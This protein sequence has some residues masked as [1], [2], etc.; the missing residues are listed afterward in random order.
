MG[1]V[2]DMSLDPGIRVRAVVLV[3][4]M[5]DRF[6]VEVLAG[7]RGRDLAAE[8]VRVVAMLGAT[9]ISHFAGRYGPQG[10]GVR[11]AGL[12]DAA[13]ED[14]FRRGLERA[15][16]GQGLT[17]AGLQALGFF[18]CTAD[19]EDELIRALG[20]GAVEQIIGAE[21]ELRSFRILQRQPAQRGRSTHDQLRRFMGCRSGRKHRYARLLAGAVDLARV[22]PALDGL[23][24]Y[25]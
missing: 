20:T 24:A 8:G 9:N 21:G 11:L 10:L 1:G 15:G 2:H 23:L 7:R 12:Y 4:G 18:R 3:E 16:L 19:L 17:R 25:V 5:S 14:H 22:P 13:E 6:A